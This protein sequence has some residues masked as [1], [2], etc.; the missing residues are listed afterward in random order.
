MS[1]LEELG[2]SRE[3]I[4]E[5]ET[6]DV[7]FGPALSGDSQS[8][9]TAADVRAGVSIRDSGGCIRRLASSWLRY[10][11]RCASAP[12]CSSGGV[13]TRSTKD[14]TGSSP[15]R[16][17]SSSDG[18][19]SVSVTRLYVRH[20]G[21]WLALFV[22]WLGGI[23]L[24]LCSPRHL[25]RP[26]VRRHLHGRRDRLHRTDG[27]R[28][29]RGG[30]GC[31]SDPWSR[32]VSRLARRPDPA[33]VR[34]VAAPRRGVVRRSSWPTAIAM[35]RKMVMMAAVPPHAASLP[36]CSYTEAGGQAGEPGGRE[37]GGAEQP[38]RRRQVLGRAAERGGDLV[39]RHG[40][41][42]G[43]GMDDRDPE[44]HP[45]ARQHAVGE[46]AD[47][48]H[49][50]LTATTRNGPRRCATRPPIGAKKIIGSVNSDRVRPMSQVSAPWSRSSTAQIAS[51]I[52][53][54]R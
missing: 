44:Q 41:R 11:T 54:V 12:S 23:A 31:D 49:V 38:L 19:R 15:S 14:S 45:E 48:R 30:G 3:D 43:D 46:R 13:D 50:R 39:A 18:S 32:G 9:Q 53:T 37:P 40:E 33:R 52:P 27:I 6:N 51:N 35:T 47:G 22:T 21:M 34:Q 26:P 42:V 16:G 1:I 4:E 24:G 10:S 20:R 29:A 25:H 36:A 28:L 17:P 5:L 2:Y 8:S 7:V